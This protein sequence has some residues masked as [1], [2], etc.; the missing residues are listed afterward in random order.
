MVIDLTHA[1][2]LLQGLPAQQQKH[3]YSGQILP[4]DIQ[5]LQSA[6]L[7]LEWF[8]MTMSHNNRPVKLPLMELLGSTTESSFSVGFF[9]P[10]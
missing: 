8:H 2:A 4:K 5:L 7:E 6:S 9:L 10:W 1:H 3:Q